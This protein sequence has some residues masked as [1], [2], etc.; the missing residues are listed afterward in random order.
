MTDLLVPNHIA[1]QRARDRGLPKQ[2]KLPPVPTA[3][4]PARL[5]SDEEYI[6]E[7]RAL[8][9]TG[10]LYVPL[11]KVVTTPVN[12]RS[13]TK[14]GILLAD[15][16]VDIQDWTHQLHKVVLVGPHVYKGPQY[17]GYDITDDQI[18]KV[19]QLW[20]VDPKHPVR[21]RY[22]GRLFLILNDD[23]LRLKAHEDDVE[24]ISF[25]GLEL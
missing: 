21:F 22:R 1:R 12:Q 24:H 23:Q 3:P 17:Q 18:P 20:I 8:V 16:S 4:L 2:I 6:T 9:D 19:G 13:I 5:K 15:E 11:W 7:L 25:N 14:G 10:K